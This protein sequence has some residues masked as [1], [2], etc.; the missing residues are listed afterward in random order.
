[1]AVNKLFDDADLNKNPAIFIP[2]ATYVDAR[3]LAAGVAETHTVPAGANKVIFSATADFYV[4][5]GGTAAVPSADV[6]DGSGSMLN[7][8]VRSIWGATTIGIIAPT[9]CIVT[10]E[11][12]K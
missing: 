9:T 7:P 10:M 11:F 1:M 8:Q 4:K 12:Y 3:V 6:T 2:Y 5:V